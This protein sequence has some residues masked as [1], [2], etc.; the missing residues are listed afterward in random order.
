MDDRRF[1]ELEKKRDSEGLSDEEANEL[2]QM[3]AERQ[4]QAYGNAADRD[5]PEAQPDGEQPYSEAEVK[6]LKQHPDVQ[7]A[8]ESEEQADKAS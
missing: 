7:E 2:G 8:S 3:I 1:Q 4:G 6:E 5:E